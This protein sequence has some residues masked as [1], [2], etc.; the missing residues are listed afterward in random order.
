MI[1]EWEKNAQKAYRYVSLVMLPKKF[2][3]GPD[4]LFTPMSLQQIHLIKN[5]NEHL[6]ANLGY[7]LK[8]SLTNIPTR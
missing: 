6:L 1:G 5:K 2:G 4:K 7:E 3:I 8:E